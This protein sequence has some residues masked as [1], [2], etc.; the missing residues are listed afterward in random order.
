MTAEVT[1]ARQRHWFLCKRRQAR[2]NHLRRPTPPQMPRGHQIRCENIKSGIVQLSA[3][4]EGF[5]G[6]D[7]HPEWIIQKPLSL[8]HE[9]CCQFT[10]KYTMSAIRGLNFQQNNE[11]TQ[12]RPDSSWEVPW[13]FGLFPAHLLSSTCSMLRRASGLPRLV[14]RTNL[15]RVDP[16]QIFPEHERGLGFKDFLCMKIN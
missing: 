14:Q 12:D 10:F 8:G 1:V 5:R 13:F 16:S 2:P 15:N 4:M 11:S 7:N 6:K 9:T 3:L